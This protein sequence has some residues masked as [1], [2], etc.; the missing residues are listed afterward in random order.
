MLRR[1]AASWE[2]VEASATLKFDC[3]KADHRECLQRVEP[4]HCPSRPTHI[5][6]LGHVSATTSVRMILMR[7]LRFA[8]THVAQP[9]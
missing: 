7:Q 6:L 8:T 1:P 3:S 9:N 4:S 2:D 5:A